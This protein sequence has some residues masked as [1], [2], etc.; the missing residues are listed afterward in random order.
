MAESPWIILVIDTTDLGAPQ[1]AVHRPDGSVALYPSAGRARESAD[2]LREWP[3]GRRRHK[4]D[5]PRRF[6]ALAQVDGPGAE[7]VGY[8]QGAPANMPIWH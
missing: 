4:G 2:R 6:W 1:T 5:K 3:K 8:D 7:P